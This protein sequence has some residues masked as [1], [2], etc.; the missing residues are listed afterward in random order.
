MR[1]LRRPRL[2]RRPAGRRVSEPIRRTLHP[3]RITPGDGDPR[4]G[5]ANG[6]LNLYCRC[7]ECRAANTRKV[8]RD[9][10]D[11]TRRLEANYASLTHG[12]DSTYQNWGCRCRPCTDAHNAAQR[13][14]WAQRRD[15]A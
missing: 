11:R 15:A 7:D 3:H 10:A 1:V 14:R 13:R 6:Y 4:H 8:R 9:R 2:A 12:N 5:T